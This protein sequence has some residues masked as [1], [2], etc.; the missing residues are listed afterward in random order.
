M[1]SRLT[2]PRRF[3]HLPVRIHCLCVLLAIAWT[4]TCDS[5]D[6]IKQLIDQDSIAW[7]SFAGTGRADSPSADKPSPPKEIALRNVYGI[8]VTPDAIFFSTV[9]DHSIWKCTRDGSSIVRFAGTGEAGY[10]GDGGPAIEATFRKPHEIRA[11][12]HGNL[13]VADTFNHC[14]RRIDA[15]S[16]QITT[17][18]GT[19]VAGFSGDDGPAAKAT[20]DQPHSIVLAG[21]DTVLVADT[22]N[23][24]LRR[25]DL[26]K[27]L[28]NTIS[29]DGKKKLPQEGAAIDQV[30]LFGPRSL[31]IDDQSIWLVLREGNSVWRIDRSANTIHRIAGTGKQGH[32]GDG[33]N[34][35]HATFRGPK[36]IGV[37]SQGNLLIVDTENHAMRYVDLN[38]NVIRTLHVGGKMK[39]PHGTAVLTDGKGIDRFFVSDSENHRVLISPSQS[40]DGSE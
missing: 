39:R 34:P 40:T 5:D 26:D 18:G 12:S 33:A 11:D 7:N 1:P 4:S 16:G 27:G 10:S 8:E 9:D 20:F 28:V 35:L 13:F 14:V 24:R 17:V 2:I 15:K 36:G 6:H 23:H 29:G 32:D 30:S 19:G 22:R 3:Y 38:N 31:A 37:D 25:I 21:D